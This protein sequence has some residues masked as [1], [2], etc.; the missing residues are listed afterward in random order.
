MFFGT[1]RRTGE[2]TCRELSREEYGE[3]ERLVKLGFLRSTPNPTMDEI[4]ERNAYL[5][6]HGVHERVAEARKAAQEAMDRGDYGKVRRPAA[7]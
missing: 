3:Q 1:K 5:V 7:C 4:E 6:A 2:P